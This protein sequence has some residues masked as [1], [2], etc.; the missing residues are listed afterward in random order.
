MK[1]IIKKLLREGLLTEKLA[2]V[3]YDVDL[4]YDRF[5]KEDIDYITRTGYVNSGLFKTNETNTVILKTPESINV[6]KTNGCIIVVNNL[7]GNFYKPNARTIGIS[8]NQ[9][10]VNFVIDEFKGDLQAA[11]NYLHEPNRSSLR[12]EFKEERIKGSIHHELVHWIDD[13][14]NNQHIK[15]RLDKALELGTR[16][17]GGVHVNST[18]MEIQ[19]Q[20]HNIKQLHNKFKDVWDDMSFTELVNN[21]PSLSLVSRQ[22]SGYIKI[23]W[24]KD[25][26][27][28]MYR[29]GLLG[30]NMIN[31]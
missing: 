1:D 29:E 13:S 16:N 5:F 8:I 26:K 9:D 20:I 31:H 19:G 21:S 30:K 3:D 25:L 17:I 18:K 6:N 10:A 12:N 7:K 28:R 11:I 27:T 23:K 4:L 24:V 14:M 15:K 22:L 2:E